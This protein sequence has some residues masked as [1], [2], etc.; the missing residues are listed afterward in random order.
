MNDLG[1]INIF[2][3]ISFVFGCFHDVIGSDHKSIENIEENL[4]RAGSFY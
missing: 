2:D 3:L 4:F 1:H